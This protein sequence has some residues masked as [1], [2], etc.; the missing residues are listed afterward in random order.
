M[1]GAGFSND[2]VFAKNVNFQGAK[3]ATVSTD[4]QLII[5]STALNAGGTHLNI[6]NLTSPDTSL[7]I[8][9]SSPNIT[10]QVNAAFLFKWQDVSG[11]FISNK[12]N[13]YFITATASST[14]P[15]GASEGDTIQYC[16]D[17]TQILTLTAS[18]G[19]KIRIGN[20]VSSVA[21]T[22]TS[23]LQGDSLYLV[24]RSVSQTW[25]CVTG[26]QGTWVLA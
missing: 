25:M 4:G 23:T 11:A 26:A 2:V 5:G 6:G 8:G 20:A 21:G 16:V 7:T 12:S 17:T 22:A 24:F 18:A 15:A 1:V 9:Y 3:S 13:G 14:L 19:Q 10:L